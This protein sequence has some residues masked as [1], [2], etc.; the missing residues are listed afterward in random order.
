MKAYSKIYAEL[1]K[2]HLSEIRQRAFVKGERE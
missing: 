1:L 2:E